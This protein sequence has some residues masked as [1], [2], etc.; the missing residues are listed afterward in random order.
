MLITFLSYS[1]S[2]K[3]MVWL[4]LDSLFVGTYLYSSQ[5]ALVSDVVSSLWLKATSLTK[6][7]LAKV[8]KY[9]PD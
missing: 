7:V 3:M 9:K 5:K 2:D 8:P 1:L 6:D 4:L